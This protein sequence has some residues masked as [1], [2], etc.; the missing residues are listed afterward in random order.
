M[1]I[2]IQIVTSYTEYAYNAIIHWPVNPCSE[3]LSKKQFDVS[4]DIACENMCTDFCAD[5]A[6][7]QGLDR[8]LPFLTF[9]ETPTN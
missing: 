3:A 9:M 8:F 2:C 4:I 5:W 1:P 6:Q 7:F